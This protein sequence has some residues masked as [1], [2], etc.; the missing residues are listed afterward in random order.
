LC[1]YG[2][3]LEAWELAFPRGFL[4]PKCFQKVL[5]HATET[6]TPMTLLV[7]RVLELL[8]VEESKRGWEWKDKVEQAV[9]EWFELPRNKR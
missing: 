2:R 6:D 4:C 7:Q 8:K 1:R 5:D 9:A 3:G